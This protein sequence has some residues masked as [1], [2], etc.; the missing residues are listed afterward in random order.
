MEINCMSACS[1]GDSLSYCAM[2]E[3]VVSMV[4]LGL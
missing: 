3:G 1:K 4:A 2:R